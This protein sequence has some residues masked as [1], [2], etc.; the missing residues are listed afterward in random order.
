MHCPV[1][2]QVWL[3]IEL[4][5]VISK[6]FI[7]RMVKKHIAS[8]FS[9]IS[10]FQFNILFT[11]TQ[12]TCAS[13]EGRKEWHGVPLVAIL[14]VQCAHGEMDLFFKLMK[15]SSSRLS[16]SPLIG[17]WLLLKFP[18]HGKC[19]H[20]FFWKYSSRETCFYIALICFG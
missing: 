1:K 16:H 8:Y 4:Y 10:Q 19:L 14:W 2:G 17:S 13:G 6:T 9:A 7:M 18:L 15:A 5:F 12:F 20:C 3:Q 11:T